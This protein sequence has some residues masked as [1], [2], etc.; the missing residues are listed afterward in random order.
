M[1][2]A[3]VG[4]NEARLAIISSHLQAIRNH[5]DLMR[6]AQVS[7]VSHAPER[8]Q[9]V[10]RV[11]RGRIGILPSFVVPNVTHGK[12]ATTNVSILSHL[13]RPSLCSRLSARGAGLFLSTEK[14]PG[15]IF[16]A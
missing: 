1:P 16:A 12:S 15:N 7:V 5:P 13:G 6:A 2:L 11:S 14:T 3:E 4:T 8:C 9:D 10:F